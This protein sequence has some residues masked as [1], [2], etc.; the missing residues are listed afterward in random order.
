MTSWYL[1]QVEDVVAPLQK[2]VETLKKGRVLNAPRVGGALGVG[3]RLIVKV[4]ALERQAHADG[5]L[6]LLHRHVR[7][8]LLHQR[9][10]RLPADIVAALVV[11]MASEKCNLG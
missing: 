2:V 7:L 8:L 9:E 10:Q 1:E 5:C 6:D 11:E 3:G 4:V